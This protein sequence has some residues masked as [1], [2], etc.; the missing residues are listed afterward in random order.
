[1]Q[2]YTIGQESQKK[3]VLTKRDQHKMF[4]RFLSVIAT[5]LKTLHE[6]VIYS[7]QM[8]ISLSSVHNG[9]QIIVGEIR[10]RF[11]SWPFKAS[12]LASRSC[13][14]RLFQLLHILYSYWNCRTLTLIITSQEFMAG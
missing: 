2:Q 10:R 3:F 7:H 11:D 14:R 5:L 13:N 9:Q 4:A 12:S 6:M 8:M 1:M